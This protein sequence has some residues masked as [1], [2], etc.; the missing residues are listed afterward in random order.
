MSDVIQLQVNCSTA[1][2]FLDAISPSGPYFEYSRI[3]EP[4]LFRGQGRDVPLIPTLFRKDGKLAS[5]TSRNIQEYSQRLLAERDLLIQFFESADRRGLALPDDSQKL[6]S[7]L[8]TL[9]SAT[10]EIN[11]NARNPDWIFRDETLSL[12]ALAQHYG[13]PTRLLDW[14]RLPLLAAYFAA[15]GPYLHPNTNPSSLMVVWAFYFPLFGK[16]DTISSTYPIR[17]VT[18]PSAS[19]ANLKAQ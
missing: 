9:N 19:N 10:G 5:F 8:E 16:H 4:W 6:R 1:R 11:L 3:S 15:E 18:A 7:M 12:A 17:V 14:T 2:E 13:L